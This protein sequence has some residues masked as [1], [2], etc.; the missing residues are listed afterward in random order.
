MSKFGIHVDSQSKARLDPKNK[1]SKLRRIEVEKKEERIN[2][3]EILAAGQKDE[4]KG[5]A[6]VKRQTE[7]E[8]KE[9]RKETEDIIN[10]LDMKSHWVDS[11]K[12]ELAKGLSQLLMNLDWI[13]GW[14]AD[15]VVTDGSPINI[16]GKPFYTKKGIL[17]VVCTPNGRVF[18]QGMLVTQ[19]PPIDYSGI[20][21]LA[22]Q[23]EN[24]MDKERG[25]LLDNGGGSSSPLVDARGNPI[26]Q[27]AK[28]TGIIL[29]NG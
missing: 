29:P 11:Y 10:K 3:E 19:E 21:T 14:T 28:N 20:Y 26:G 16:K 25:L 18:H 24:T 4:K 2:R 1:L 27:S 9:K 17:L 8:I 15:V 13:R 7:L 5:M 22:L 23:V 12:R 6:E